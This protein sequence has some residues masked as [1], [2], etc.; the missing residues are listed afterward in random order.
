MARWEAG[1]RDLVV[2]DPRM[3][4]QLFRCRPDSRL[5]LKRLPMLMSLRTYKG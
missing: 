5:L 4:Q 2:L 1:W 3:V